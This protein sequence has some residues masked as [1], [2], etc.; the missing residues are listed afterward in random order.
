MCYACGKPLL[1]VSRDAG[2]TWSDAALP[3][4]EGA[5]TSDLLGAAAP[6]TF[7]DSNTGFFA[8]NQARTDPARDGASKVFGTADGGKTWSLVAR[9]P[10]WLESLVA[11]DVDHWFGVAGGTADVAASAVA[12][13][14][15][16]KTWHEVAATFP[17]FADLACWFVDREHGA[18]ILAP[19]IF[20]YPAKVLYVTADGGK[21]W[22]PAPL[23]E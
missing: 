9:T 1:Q 17:R 7:L 3:G 12:T 20:N 19:G 22:N 4:Y 5:L 11:V 13:D 23:G 2:V 8:V 21:T 14:D 15:G 10:Y 18:A 6:P 16:G